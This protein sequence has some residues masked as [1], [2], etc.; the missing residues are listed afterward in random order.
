A[1]RYTVRS[2]TLRYSATCRTVHAGLGES[3]AFEVFRS[4]KVST[5]YK[6]RHDSARNDE[7]AAVPASPPA[8]EGFRTR[9]AQ[10]V[11]GSQA[12]RLTTKGLRIRSRG[13]DPRRRRAALS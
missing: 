1:I 13:V 8:L 2:L 7:L 12:A 10:A 9:P 3:V 11:A 4:V 6:T 5:Q